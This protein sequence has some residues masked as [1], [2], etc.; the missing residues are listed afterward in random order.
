MRV[1]LLG[2]IYLSSGNILLKKLF[3]EVEV[4]RF[5]DSIVVITMRQLLPYLV[6]RLADIVQLLHVRWSVVALSVLA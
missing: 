4:S 2:I 1:L 5:G 3:H 6:L